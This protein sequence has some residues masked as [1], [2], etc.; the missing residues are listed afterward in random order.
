MPKWVKPLV[1]WLMPKVGPRG[2]EF[3]RARVEMKAIETILHLRREAPARMKNMVPSHVWD[4]V[5]PYGLTQDP[6]ESTKL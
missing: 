4:L 6:P 2:L 3:A 1:N 5:R